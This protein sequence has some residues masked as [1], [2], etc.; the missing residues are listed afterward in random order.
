MKISKTCFLI[1]LTFSIS[2]FSCS[3]TDEES[4]IPIFKIS[5]QNISEF[6]EVISSIEFIPLKNNND[7]P[8]NLNCSVWNLTVTANY[9]VYSTIC[10][11]EAKI[12]LFD[13][14]GN[15][16]KS[17]SKNGNDPEEYQVKMKD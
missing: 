14:K 9:F 6:D 2:F 11:P 1:I 4:G 12:H 7:S 16:I 15:Y 10:N 8:V 5:D 13:L 3:P 17:L